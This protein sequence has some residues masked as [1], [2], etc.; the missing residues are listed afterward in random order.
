ML[1]RAQKRC[2]VRKTILSFCN[3]DRQIRKA[4]F[5]EVC[6]LFLRCGRNGY[7]V[8]AVNFAHDFFDFLRY[9]IAILI[10]KREIAF[11]LFAKSHDFFCKRFAALAAVRPHG[12]QN[13]VYAK[14]FAFCDDKINLFVRVCREAVDCHDAR[15]FVNVFDV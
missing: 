4:E 8:A 3:A 15:Q 1:G 7:A 13:G 5:F 6:N 2:V 10:R 11:F 9:G 12:R 14:L